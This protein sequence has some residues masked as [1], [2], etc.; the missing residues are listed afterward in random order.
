MHDDDAC[1]VLAHEQFEMR[2]IALCTTSSSVINYVIIAPVMGSSVLQAW[3]G[4]SGRGY[5]PLNRTKDHCFSMLSKFFRVGKEFA[6]RRP[7]V[8]NCLVYGTLYC[9]AECSQ[10][11]LR[12]TVFLKEGELK[13][14]YDYASLG[15]Y[16]LIGSAVFPIIL[17][18]WYKWLDA[19]YPINAGITLVKKVFLDQALCTPFNICNFYIIMSLLEGKDDPL[20]EVRAKLWPT[21]LTSCVYWI[22]MTS[23]NFLLMPPSARVVYVAWFRMK[24]WRYLKL[25]ASVGIP[26][27]LYVLYKNDWDIA[28][29]G[30][31]RF[32][33][34]GIVVASIA[35]DYRRNLY[36]GQLD[37]NSEDYA[38][39]RSEIHK[40]SAQKLFELCCRNGGAFIKC[41]QHIGALDYL[42]P[43]EYVSRMKT[44]HSDAPKS[45]L[46]NLLQVVREDLQTEPENVFSEISE[47]PLGAASLA[48]VHK[49]VL[50]ESG[51]TVAVKIQHPHVKD[52]SIVDMRTME[53]LLWMVD[54]YFYPD[55][56]F[57]WLAESARENLPK[58]LDFTHEARNM[59]KVRK[60]F[61]HLKWLRVPKVRWQ[62]TTPRVLVMDF[63]PGESVTDLENLNKHQIPPA[64]VTERLG[65]LY[66]AMIFEEGFVHCDPHPG[67]LLVS[68]NPKN[69]NDPII[70][71]LD[72]GLYQTLRSRFRLSYCHLWMSVLDRDIP[73]IKKHSKELQVGDLAELF[74][75]MVT[76]RSWASI[77]S[78]IDKAGKSKAE[79]NEIRADAGK[80]LPQISAVSFANHELRYCASCC[81]Y[82]LFYDTFLKPIDLQSRVILI[83][84]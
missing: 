45:K 74:A 62:W 75:C 71:L 56:Q 38:N 53:V 57:S 18:Y 10:Q 17:Y 4:G 79:E 27:C 24:R 3:F 8:V 47:E 84:V 20:A 78:G 43:E 14:D 30:I 16:A 51:E 7:L 73:G 22:P 6:K 26:G 31:S 11:T 50:K 35:M 77:T 44:L 32:G 13:P 46:K 55:F 9:G 67:N 82:S 69:P 12:R 72:H 36:T 60:M 54:K 34:A 15:R 49:A 1:P 65:E 21:Y 2:E 29:T 63:C 68:P 52:R 19:R 48:Q 66:S 33:R 42:L 81:F 76:G 83:V 61:S 28:M 40:R 80:Y 64:L 59:S 41:G 23:I 5:L 39:L 70:T 58:E 25:A 37:A